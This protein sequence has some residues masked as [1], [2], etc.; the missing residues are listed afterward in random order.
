MKKRATFGEVIIFVVLAALFN[1]PIY[2]YM[3]GVVPA[4]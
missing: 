4:F 2:L 3:A 1:T